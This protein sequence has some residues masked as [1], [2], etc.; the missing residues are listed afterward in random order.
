MWIGDH[1]DSIPRIDRDRSGIDP[2]ERNGDQMQTDDYV[3]A[4]YEEIRLR[5]ALGGTDQARMKAKRRKWESEPKNNPGSL[6]RIR[7]PRADWDAAMTDIRE[8]R[9][10]GSDP[11]DPDQVRKLNILDSA[12]DAFREEQKRAADRIEALQSDLTAAQTEA[13]DL[14]IR[15]AVAEA[16]LEAAEAALARERDRADR[17]D[18]EARRPWWKRLIGQP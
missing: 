9:S 2:Q 18:A 4:T 16:K 13:G 7:V 6:T 8:D 5:F 14:K 15:A 12:V 11:P 10:R 17:A 1:S 3:V